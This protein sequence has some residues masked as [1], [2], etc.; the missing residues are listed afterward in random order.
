MIMSLFAL[1]GATEEGLVYAVMALGLFVSYRILNIADMTVD[2]SLALGA[3]ISALFTRMGHPFLGLLFAVIGGYLAG[4]I[5]A[6]L[7]TKL[8]IQPILAGILTMTAFYSIN[9][10]V[11]GGVP[12]LPL[13]GRTSAFSLIPG[14]L[15]RLLTGLVFVA[16]VGV[17]LTFFFRTQTGLC[18]R[19][20]GDNEDMVLASSINTD[21]IKFIGL[22]L[23]NALAGFSGGLLAQYQGFADLT[24]GTGM[25]VVGLASLI[26]GE[27][28][29][30]KPTV[31][32]NIL[33]IIL[34][35]I[36]YR[37]IIAFVLALGLPAADLK[38]I[39]SLVVI[40][41]ISYPVVLHQLRV[42]KLMK[43]A[44]KHA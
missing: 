3:A 12:N 18:I 4:T 28:V 6:F 37:I 5:T 31:W 9:L 26:I 17:F 8:H 38:L 36:V 35:S 34:G 2:G 43:E 10:H 20:T 16:L 44:A 41:A 23:A 22:G 39:S 25:V 40:V 24:T 42:Q 7:Q 27:V 32:R 1:Q 29:F 13:L 33:A 11:M 19:A 15:G 14:S 30:K 21:R